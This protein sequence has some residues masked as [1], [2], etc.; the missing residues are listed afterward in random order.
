M[1]GWSRA[2]LIPI[3]ASKWGFKYWAISDPNGYMLDC[4]IYFGGA[5][6]ATSGNGVAYDVA[7][8]LTRPFCF[9]GYHVY[10]SNF[11]SSSPILFEELMRDGMFATGTLCGNQAGVPEAVQLMKKVFMKL[12][13]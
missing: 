6:T 5:A 12:Y 1:R 13:N 2:R 7:V 8:E 9:Q 3:T 10:C 11:Y 4:N